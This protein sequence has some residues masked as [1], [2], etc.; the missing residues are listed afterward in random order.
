MRRAFLGTLRNCGNR[1][2]GNA[3]ATPQRAQSLVGGGFDAN[4]VV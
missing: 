4:P 1:K 2:C 3:F